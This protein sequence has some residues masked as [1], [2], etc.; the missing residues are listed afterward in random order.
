MEES[1]TPLRLSAASPSSAAA[2][3][4]AAH[5]PSVDPSSFV[6]KHWDAAYRVA[7]LITLNPEES[8]DIAQESM[9]SALRNLDSLDPSRPAGPWVR[10]IAAN[11]TYARYRRAMTRQEELSGSPED[12]LAVSDVDE[13]ARL[14]DRL[15]LREAMKDL[16]VRLRAV[17]VMRYLLDLPSHEIAA[18]LGIAEGTVRSRLSRGLSELRHALHTQQGG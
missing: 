7:Y 2:I 13:L 8:A 5:A 12:E 10:R 11:A 16:D 14:A 3:D 1:I 15:D 9:I 6:Q 4:R 17:V 18:A